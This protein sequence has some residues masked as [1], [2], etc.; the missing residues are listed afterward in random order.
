VERTGRELEA[1]HL[2]EERGQE[3]CSCAARLVAAGA[4][5]AKKRVDLVEEDDRRR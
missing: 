3:L 1:V 5:G 4:S 2:N